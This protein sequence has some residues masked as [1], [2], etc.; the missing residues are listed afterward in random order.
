MKRAAPHGY[1]VQ[2]VWH[3]NLSG[4]RV[5]DIVASSVGP[6]MTIP[7]DLPARSMDL[8]VLSQDRRTHRWSV[9][10]DAQRVV[11]AAT[12]PTAM[13]DPH[14]DVS[15]GPVR[16]VHILSRD[17]EQLVFS[18]SNNY[19]G[20][21]IPM[22]LAVL[23]LESGQAKLVYSWSGQILRGW[24]VAHGHIYARAAYWTENEPHCCPLRLYRFTIAPRHGALVEVSDDRPRLGVKVRSWNRPLKV[25]EIDRNSPALGHLRVGDVL[26]K[27]LNAPRLPHGKQP[28]TGLFDRIGLFHPG[29]VVQLLAERNGKKIRIHVKLGSKMDAPVDSSNFDL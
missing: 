10:F 25:I 3:A 26:L 7:G 16:F 21:G 15:L 13:L 1:R 27:V 12:E 2:H 8:R 24:H 20:S 14:A 4:G 23:D 17:R 11:P 28:W 5:R 19:Y 22:W 29:Q 9:T 18:A 6:R